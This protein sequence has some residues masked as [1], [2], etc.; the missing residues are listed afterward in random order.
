[1][2]RKE[3]IAASTV[4]LFLGA[5]VVGP[6]YQ[7]PTSSLFNAPESQGSF[8]SKTKAIVVEAPVSNWWRLYNDQRLGGF[9][10]KALVA[11]TDLRAAEANLERAHALLAEAETARQ[12]N[13]AANFDTSYVQQ[14]AESYLS[15]TKPPQHEIANTGISI[16]YDLDLFGRIR[17]G[18][19]SATSADEAAV[20]ARDLVRVNVAA[21]TTRAYADICNSGNE[22]NS[23]RRTVRV[24][25]QAIAFTGTLV[26]SGRAARFDIDR[27]QG[28]YAELQ[29][30]IPLLEARQRNAAYRL[31]TLV[32]EPPEKLD[33]A[34][35]SCKSPLELSS[36]IAVGDARAL[37]RRR[38]DVRAAERRLAAATAII[39]VETADLYPD[40]KI[41]ASIGTQGAAPDL[42]GALTNRFGVGPTISWNINQNVARA[43]IA[44]AQA[45]SR[46][47]LASFDRAVL[48]A[49]REIESSLTS[50][51]FSLDRLKN[52]KDARDRAAKVA[53]DARELWQ[54]GSTDALTSLEADRSLA[55]AEQAYAAGQTDVN[56]NQIAIFL[57][58]GG[59]W[60]A[61]SQIDAAEGLAGKG[62]TKDTH[63][64]AG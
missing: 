38:P 33:R 20:A 49:L 23:A 25:K 32:G 1:M 63:S 29:S 35:L 5:C 4:C 39:G 19:E 18:I 10:E 34:L 58:L 60:E 52:L 13:G 26:S 46:A 40:V 56:L 55:A 9:V 16:T 2:V 28:L 61:P 31:M 42:F 62:E 37:L 43:R 17:R 21:D 59:G 54:G 22:L 7:L 3:T 48:T 27:Q 44:A 36:P 57:A 24:Q 64:H 53:K 14:S 47:D 11:N 30:R 51:A 45:Q 6:N 41:G 50:Y 12:I 8:S 15:H